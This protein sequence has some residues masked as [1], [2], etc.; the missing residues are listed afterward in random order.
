MKVN[1]IKQNSKA[2]RD[3][4]LAWRPNVSNTRP[5]LKLSFKGKQTAFHTKMKQ[6]EHNFLHLSKNT[7]CYD[8]CFSHNLYITFPI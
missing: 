6:K 4:M 1:A 5:T 2:S 8:K 3:T 7:F